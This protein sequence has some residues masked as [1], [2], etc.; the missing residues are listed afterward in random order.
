MH[1]DFLHSLKTSAVASKAMS[2]T[3]STG[4]SPTRLQ[5][6]CFE[7]ASCRTSNSDIHGLLL[8]LEVT[9]KSMGCD[10]WSLTVISRPSRWSLSCRAI[11]LSY[12]GCMVDIRSKFIQNGCLPARHLTKS[13]ASF[14]STSRIAEAKK[15]CQRHP[16]R[17]DEASPSHFIPV[18]EHD[19]QNLTATDLLRG[20]R[21]VFERQTCILNLARQ[22]GAKCR[23]A[24]AAS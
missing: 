17:L 15:R 1:R 18:R 7:T 10:S 3:S 20:P 16:S 12:R 9:M 11:G 19:E 24:F 14:L 2:T 21:R 5:L 8:S 6:S 4:A 22:C 23:S 13:T